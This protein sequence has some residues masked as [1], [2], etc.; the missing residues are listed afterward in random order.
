[1]YPFLGGG[2]I[3]CSNILWC[4]KFCEIFGGLIL[5]AAVTKSY[6]IQLVSLWIALAANL[7]LSSRALREDVVRF[8][9]SGGT[10]VTYL[11]PYGIPCV[12]FSFCPLHRHA[13][14]AVLLVVFSFS[15]HNNPVHPPQNNKLK[16]FIFLHADTVGSFN[17]IFLLEKKHILK[18]CDER[19]GRLGG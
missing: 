2:G 13:S 3:Y 14:S 5:P 1:M 17:L 15:F 4:G 12:S 19:H 7:R 9:G 18:T 11:P 10:S 8:G 16:S 6:P